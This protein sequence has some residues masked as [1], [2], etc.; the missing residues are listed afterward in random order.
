[1]IS[2]LFKLPIVISIPCQPKDLVALVL[3]SYTAS[4]FAA[5]S[6][7]VFN[8]IKTGATIELVSTAEI[9]GKAISKRF[10]Q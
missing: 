4:L 9:T 1:V 5:L 6:S 2:S 3:T 10:F 8:V 7:V